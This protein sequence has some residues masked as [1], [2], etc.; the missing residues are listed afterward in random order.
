VKGLD[1]IATIISRC[2]MRE[3]LYRRRYEPGDH[4]ESKR[5][6][7]ASHSSY[8]DALRALYVKILNFQ[9]NCICFLS[10][11][12]F[13]RTTADMVKWNDWDKM[14]AEVEEQEQFLKSIEEQWRDM[15]YEEE[16]RLFNDQHERRMAGLGA[17]EG[18]VSRVRS[19]IL[20][21]QNNN[22]REKLLNWL[23]S[24][25][26]SENYNSARASHASSTGDWLVEKSSDFKNWETAPNSLLWLHGKGTIPL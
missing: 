23:S 17:I 25:D 20:Q 26:P 9:V 19:V 18:E 14:L 10:K 15:K 16:C 6:F 3:A 8:R 11:N 21:V 24:V 22:E 2:T 4:G 13:S 1:Y 12:T 5:E 7:M